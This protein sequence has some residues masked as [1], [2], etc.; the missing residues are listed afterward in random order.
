MGWLRAYIR[1][2]M[3]PLA[4]VSLVFLMVPSC[5][6]VNSIIHDDEVV[7]RVGKNMLYKSE[8]DALIHEGISSEDSLR[9]VMQYINT[10]A[11]DMIFID[12][13]ETQLSKKE[14]DVSKELESYRR[15]LLKYR[16]EQ[17]YVNERLDTA[18]TEREIIEYYNSHQKSFVLQNPIVKARLWKTATTSSANIKEMKTLM[19]EIDEDAMWEAENL[20][21]ANAEVFSN[22]GDKWI[23]IRR[24]AKD[25]GM[26]QEKI[27]ASGEGKFIEVDD[28][29]GLRSIVYIME[30]VKAGEQAPVEYCSAEISDM[31]ISVRKRKLT[32]TL[33]QELVSSARDKGKFVIY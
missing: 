32:I 8:V 31:I 9:L 30:L 17:H 26:E 3:T 18:V 7:A 24:L 25:A 13:A 5:K 20:A 27:L 10:W 15:S 16:Y 21:Y 1:K 14:M 23:D 19:S 4:V 2:H 6:L 33:E 22:Y 11:S 28:G 29:S 12:I